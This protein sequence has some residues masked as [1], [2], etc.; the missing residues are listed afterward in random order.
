MNVALRP[1]ALYAF[2]PLHISTK[3]FL[4]AEFQLFLIVYQSSHEGEL[5]VVNVSSSCVYL[6]NLTFLGY[7]VLFFPNYCYILM[8]DA[9]LE[10]G[11][12]QVSKQGGDVT[13][14]A[15]FCQENL[16][17]KAVLYG[18]SLCSHPLSF[19][20]WFVYEF[21]RSS[22]GLHQTIFTLLLVCYGFPTFLWRYFQNG[23]SENGVV[24]SPKEY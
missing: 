7:F 14:F 11:V 17:C 22:V 1:N 16:L 21:E 6:V 5:Q 9:V 3:P 10:F 2:W 24:A 8:I 23:F 13:G 12:L 4:Q 15:F 18:V 20:G 19:A